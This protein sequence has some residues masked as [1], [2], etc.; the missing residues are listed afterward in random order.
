[1]KFGLIVIVSLLEDAANRG[2][3]VSFDYTLPSQAL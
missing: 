3:R 1:M 2:D